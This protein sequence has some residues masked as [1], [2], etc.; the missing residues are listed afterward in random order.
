MSHASC[1]RL[2]RTALRQI[3]FIRTACKGKILNAMVLSFKTNGSVQT[4][5]TQIGLPL[6]E[7]EICVCTVCNTVHP[8]VKLLLS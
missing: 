8:L 6:E 2:G 7:L 1:V 5:Q 4:V 3:F